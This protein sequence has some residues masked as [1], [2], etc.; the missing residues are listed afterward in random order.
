MVLREICSEVDGSNRMT[1]PRELPARR[2]SSGH[3]GSFPFAHTEGNIA[4]FHPRRYPD[5][6][7]G[8]ETGNLISGEEVP[9]N[10]SLPRIVAHDQASSSSFAAVIDRQKQD[11]FLVS[12]EP[13]VHRQSVVMKTNDGRVLREEKNGRG[14][15]TWFK[16]EV[17]M[18]GFERG[19]RSHRRPGAGG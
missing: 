18:S 5:R 2:V 12:L 9:H 3:D 7:K 14:G 6:L 10:G 16:V 15:G 17:E 13:T 19:R 1:S 4:I 11:S 8:C